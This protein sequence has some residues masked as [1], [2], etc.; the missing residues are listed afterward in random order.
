M[1]SLWIP[2]DQLVQCQDSSYAHVPLL[3]WSS[4]AF[5]LCFLLV[6]NVEV[7]LCKLLSCAVLED[8]SLHWTWSCDPVGSP[9]EEFLMPPRCLHPPPSL[10][11]LELHSISATNSHCLASS[12]QALASSWSNYP[13]GQPGCSSAL[14]VAQICSG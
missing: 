2:W 13:P 1:I 7:P 9:W 14:V 3:H 8:S 10:L 6:P 12:K 5:G 11:E 4:T